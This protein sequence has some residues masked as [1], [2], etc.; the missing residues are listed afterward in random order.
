MKR[1]ANLI[2]WGGFAVVLLAVASYIPLFVRFPIT[3]DIPWVSYLLLLTG[4]LLLGVGLKRAFG[5]TQLYRGKISGSILSVLSLLIGGLFCFG[6]IIASKQIPA[7]SDAVR[8]SQPA[9][10]FTLTGADGKQVALA[11]LLRNNRGALLIFYRGYW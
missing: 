10:P 9:P 11:D 3:R 2:L 7:S 1:R 4:A 5:Q 8:V 6:V